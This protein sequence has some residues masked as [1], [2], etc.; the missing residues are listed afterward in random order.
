[1]PTPGEQ[2]R[3]VV[4]PANWVDRHGDTLYRFAI[5][6]LRDEETA[7]EVVQETLVAALRARDQYAGK[8]SEGAWLLGI[9]KRKVVDHVRRRSRP[10]AASGG[11]LGSDPSEAMF[12]AK[13]N[14]RFD[15]RVLKGRPE[16]ALERED[17][18]LAFR[19]CLERLSQRQADAFALREI[20]DMSS[21]EIC[22]E[23]GVSASNLWVLLH[24]AR[25]GLTRCMK[26]HL[27]KEGAH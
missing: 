8:G 17:F 23:L 18:W 13:G 2:P 12:D 22:K 10:D 6:R 14:W 5:S 19:G 27:E 1:M 4:D 24:R 26:S 7:E 11:E 21:D 20:E 3:G 15:P 16:A 25:L 9:C